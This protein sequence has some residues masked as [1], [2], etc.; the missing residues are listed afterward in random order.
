M[1]RDCD[2]ELCATSAKEK[3]IAIYQRT[4]DPGAS[5]NATTMAMLAPGAKPSA[6]SLSVWPLPAALVANHSLTHL[7]PLRSA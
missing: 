3:A 6:S 2:T 7:L 1:A 4:S 5:A